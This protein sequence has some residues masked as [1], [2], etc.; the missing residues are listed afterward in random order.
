MKG[1][2]EGSRPWNRAL[3]TRHFD[4]SSIGCIRQGPE[5]RS[6]VESNWFRS[7]HLLRWSRQRLPCRPESWCWEIP[8]DGNRADG[9]LKTLII[10]QNSANFK[11]F[12]LLSMSHLPKGVLGLGLAEEKTMR[13]RRIK[14]DPVGLILPCF[15][16][17]CSCEL[18]RSVLMLPLDLDLGTFLVITCNYRKQVY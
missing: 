13:M 6:P 15:I 16:T 8:R 4:R 1:S 5:E 3:W 11:Q 9:S 14:V 2:Q 7:L 17:I 18:S 10:T 12:R